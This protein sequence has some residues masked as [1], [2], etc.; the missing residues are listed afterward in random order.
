MKNV[1]QSF[2]IYMLCDWVATVGT[3]I[4]TTTAV[5]FVTLA[6]QTFSNPYHGI[7]VFLILPGLFLVGLLLIPIGIWRCSK[8]AGGISAIAQSSVA[9]SRAMR[10]LGLVA[11]LTVV[12]VAIISAASYHGVSYMDSNAFCGT[13]CHSVM[14][15]QYNA[16]QESSHSRVHC[17]SCH[18]GSGAESFVQYKLAGVRQLISLTLN[19]YHRP[20]PPA[21]DTLRPASETCEHCHS[22]AKL[23]ED[24]VRILRRYD[25]DEKSTEKVTVL[26]MRTASRIHKAHVGQKIEFSAA[27]AGKQEIPWV[28]SNGIEYKAADASGQRRQ[29]DCMDC[30]NRSGHDFDMPAPAIDRVIEAGELDRTTPFAKRDGVLALTGKKA[31]DQ[32]P[33]AVR[34]VHA[35]N[36][37]PRLELTWGSYPSNIGHDQSPGCFRCHDDNHKSSEGK[38]ITQDCASCHELL[39]VAE[40]N[41]EILK[42]LGIV[43]KP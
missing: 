8:R 37:Y 13:V 10:L 21:L 6:F 38:T 26:L 28:S 39:A 27:D 7:L 20:I 5:V 4:V 25:E 11:F 24:R 29:M 43:N 41:P 17:V 9:G 32:S 2:L 23:G 30:H 16:Y 31:V 34:R 35:R 12:N 19:T 15:P 22:P 36:I 40:E 42:Q 3:V 18:I 1:L 14:S 33:E